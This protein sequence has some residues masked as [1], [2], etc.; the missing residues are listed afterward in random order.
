MTLSTF[1]AFLTFLTQ[2]L[3]FPVPASDP[4]QGLEIPPHL[5]RDCLA[6]L[7]VLLGRPEPAS[8]V[9][10]APDGASRLGA[11]MTCLISAR[12]HPVHGRR[13]LGLGRRGTRCRPRTISV[14]DM[15]VSAGKKPQ[16]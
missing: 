11:A 13:W 3:C 6:P 10:M 15:A 2:A 16:G 12:R 5:R 14:S 4:W 7:T 8:E 9:A 1:P